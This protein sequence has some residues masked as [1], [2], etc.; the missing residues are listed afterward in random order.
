VAFLQADLL[1]ELERPLPP[2]P[3]VSAAVEA[4][5]LLETVTDALPG[6]EGAVRVLEDGLDGPGPAASFGRRRPSPC[7]L[8]P[9]D[10][11]PS[12]GRRLQPEEHAGDGRLP[13]S[14]LT[15]ECQRTARGDAEGEV[16]HRHHG[17]PVPPRPEDLAQVR[18][19]QDGLGGGRPRRGDPVPRRGVHGEPGP[20]Q[21]RGV[22]MQRT[23]VEV[24]GTLHLHNG[25]GVQD[26]GPVAGG[27]GQLEVMG[28]EQHG[29]TE[30]LT[31]LGENRQHLGLGDGVQRG[32][33]FVGEQEPGLGRECGRDHHPL[34]EAAGQ[35][36]GIAGQADPGVLDAHGAEQ[37]AGPLPAGPFGKVLVEAE[38]F[39]E[40]VP[41]RAQGV[42][43]GTWVLEDDRRL[44]GAVGAELGRGHRQHVPSVEPHRALGPGAGGEQAQHRPGGHRLARTGLADQPDRLAGGDRQVHPADHHPRRAVAGNV[45]PQ[46]LDLQ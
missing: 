22:G 11:D 25:A 17:G 20:D 14:R 46:P 30:P 41:D 10:P 31:E 5:R 29:Q 19:L 26:R 38:A 24:G 18:D 43:V 45:D 9:G 15:D 6:I 37:L 33:G 36:V 32:G 4:E 42:G 16:V 1:Q 28:D 12:R 13:R 23:V 44:V 21:P 39:G 2:G 7:R 27:G 3:A 34:E 35:L 40:V 8:L